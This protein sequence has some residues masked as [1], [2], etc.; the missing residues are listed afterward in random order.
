MFFI[1]SPLSKYDFTSEWWRKNVQG[2]GSAGLREVYSISLSRPI[3]HDSRGAWWRSVKTKRISSP[4]CLVITFLDTTSL[5][6]TPF[7]RLRTYV[8]IYSSTVPTLGVA[9]YSSTLLP[10]ATSVLFRAKVIVLYGMWFYQVCNYIILPRL[11][12][13]KQSNNTL[14]IAPI[15]VST[16][17]S[18]FHMFTVDILTCNE[19]PDVV[20]FQCHPLASHEHDAWTRTATRFRRCPWSAFCSVAHI[21]CCWAV[22]SCTH[23]WILDCV[24]YNLTRK[25]VRGV[26][27]LQDS[28][29]R[30]IYFSASAISP[31]WR[32]N[33]SRL[34]LYIQ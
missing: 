26:S 1:D 16:S 17:W 25:R 5:H 32:Q 28:C 27:N 20:Q 23:G 33:T 14:G 15:I 12:K 13:S 6:Q 19:L 29:E 30:S 4:I 18:S 22:S 8:W 7:R 21:W 2:I 3:D 10:G 31:H 11:A 34:F 24:Q 9:P